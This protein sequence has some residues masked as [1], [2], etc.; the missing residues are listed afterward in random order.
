MRPPIRPLRFVDG[1]LEL[2]DQTKLPHDEVWIRL[3]QPKQVIEAISML[4][5]R[6]APAIGVAGAYAVVLAAGDADTVRA[7][8]S[9]IAAARPTAVNLGWAVNRM[10]RDRLASLDASLP[11]FDIV[12]M[13]QRIASSI[14]RE[15]FSAFL[16]ASFSVLGVALAL[17]GV[18]S[19]I[20]HA[21]SGRTREIGIRLSLGAT[22][23]DV[24]SLVLRD[25]ALLTAAGVVAG[26]GGA[27]A[28]SRWLAGELYE[29]GP[30]DPATYVSLGLA[31]A[32]V[33]LLACYVP[34]RRALKVDPVIAL[35]DE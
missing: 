19:V 4:R 8:A 25:G 2:L 35:R 7:E 22:R 20:S 24:L 15:R 27:L 32:T 5:V 6:G 16:L 12:A 26:F 18:Y 1:A 28:A 31:M 10:L 13:E 14:S 34:A 17:I 11:L 29:V 30:F 33:A 21:V 3:T 9:K 23:R